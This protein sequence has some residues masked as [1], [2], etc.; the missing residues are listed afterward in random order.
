MMTTNAPSTELDQPGYGTGNGGAL[1][2]AVQLKKYFPVTRGLLITK[3][4]G[5]IKA[6]ERRF[7]SSCA[8]ERRWE[9]LA[10]RAAAR[11]P[12]PR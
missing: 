8:R 12:P 7:H 11:A 10:S 9:S 1:L 4:T 5:H 3:T 6:V 2:E